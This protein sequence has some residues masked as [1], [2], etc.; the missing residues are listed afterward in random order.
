MLQNLYITFQVVFPFMAYLGLGLLLKAVH[1]VDDAFL[2]R[3]NHFLTTVLLPVKMFDSI[4]NKDLAEA[5][6]TPVAIYA[7][8]G[9]VLVMLVTLA[10][11][12][13]LEKDPAKQGAL[14]HAI[15]RG[16]V[17]LFALPMAQGI[18]G[19]DVAEIVIVLAV[20]VLVNNV[21]A[22]P[23]MEHFRKKVRIAKGELSEGKHTSV[24]QL[25]LDCLKTPLLDSVI[26]GILWSLSGLSLPNFLA[27][28]VGG[29]ADTVVPLAFLVLGASLN[30]GHLKANRRNVIL[31]VFMKLVVVP[32]V[33][34]ILPI[35]AGWGEKSIVACLVAFGSP[36]AVVAY[37]MT[38]TYEC[39]GHLA[40][41][42]VSLTSFLSMFSIFLW[43]FSLRQLGIIS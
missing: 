29:L 5:F 24:K 11:V 30:L 14:V 18:F 3:L 16:N 13:R 9:T 1:A 15:A 28:P 33:F 35:A 36:T 7:G 2:R 41:E 23:L 42:I 37:A 20:V 25:L 22:V 32:A 10:L 8:L 34:I 19:E 31:S 40:G 38:E 6:R 12:S 21:Q 4:Y 39:D 43:I 26:L 27:V 17:M